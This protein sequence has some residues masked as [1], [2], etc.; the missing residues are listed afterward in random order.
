MSIDNDSIIITDN[1]DISL[2]RE[3]E[4]RNK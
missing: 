3:A 1:K 4:K 2:M